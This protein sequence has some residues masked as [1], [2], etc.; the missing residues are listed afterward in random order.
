MYNLIV[1]DVR[2]HK[3]VQHLG[4]CYN[5]YGAMLL[6]VVFSNAKKSSAGKNDTAKL[7]LFSWC[8]IYEL[9]ICRQLK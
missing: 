8:C 1:M 6:G 9:P 3:I 5:L 2:H 4:S 7:Q